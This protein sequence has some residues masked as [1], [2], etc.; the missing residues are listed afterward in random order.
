MGHE[1][2]YLKVDFGEKLILIGWQLPNQTK[3]WDVE[4]R[5]RVGTFNQLVDFQE[6]TQLAQAV[7][8]GAPSVTNNPSLE[9]ALRPAPCEDYDTS[10][11]KR[12]EAKFSKS[13]T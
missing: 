6:T 2:K 5:D 12:S 8:P 10:S 1:I 11:L 7:F 3:I 9:K 4:K 13:K